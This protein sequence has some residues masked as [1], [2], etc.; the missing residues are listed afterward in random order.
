[1]RAENGIVLQGSAY[2]TV[3]AV[4]NIHRSYQL[5]TVFCKD[6]EMPVPFRSQCLKA[7]FIKLFI[8]A[9]MTLRSKLTKACEEVPMH[10][11][12]RN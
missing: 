4:G 12:C 1:M 6:V 3:T 11:N 2:C 7:I 5:W 9:H 10:L 8:A